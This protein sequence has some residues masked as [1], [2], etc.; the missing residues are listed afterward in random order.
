VL[1][2]ATQDE[3]VGEHVDDI[4]GL[5][6]SLN[7][8]RKQRM[9]EF[10]DDVQHAIFSPVMGSVL[11]EVLGP[12]VIGALGAQADARSV[13]EPE[14]PALGLF[15]R[16]LQ[17]LAPP[18]AFNPLVIDDPTR[19][20]PKHLRDLPIAITA[21]LARKLDEVGGQ[22]LLVV[23]PHW[24]VALRGTMLPER[25]ANPALGQFQLGSNMINAGAA[26]RGA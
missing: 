1:G 21:I 4:G 12:D 13:I 16:N 18:D 25:P 7:A 11:D 19:R 17:S 24:N 9:V 5:E 2:H 10:V 3:Q 14:P 26:A 20:R 6:P 22:P 15:S 23:S 8:D